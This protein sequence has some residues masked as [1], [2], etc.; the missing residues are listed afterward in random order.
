MEHE[1]D[2]H[3][4]RAVA[5]GDRFTERHE[6]ARPDP[7][8]EARVVFNLAEIVRVF[9]FE[10]REVVVGEVFVVQ[11]TEEHEREGR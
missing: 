4:G 2:V 8:G 5:L 10:P 11:I 3:G 1:G 7:G 9:L 6:E